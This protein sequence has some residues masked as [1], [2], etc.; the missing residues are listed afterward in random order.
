MDSGCIQN[1]MLLPSWNLFTVPKILSS[2]FIKAMRAQP[3]QQINSALKKIKP[4]CSVDSVS[5]QAYVQN[6]KMQRH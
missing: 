6:F 2:I 3:Q 4:Y 1:I 5:I